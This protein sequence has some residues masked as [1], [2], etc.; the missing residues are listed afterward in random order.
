MDT[1]R[2]ITNYAAKAVRDR[3]QD[4]CPCLAKNEERKGRVG[5]FACEGGLI[6]KGDGE[7]KPDPQL[8]KYEKASR[9]PQGWE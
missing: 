6:G 1:K 4:L 9:N 2:H 3:V 7:G 5:Y 8:L